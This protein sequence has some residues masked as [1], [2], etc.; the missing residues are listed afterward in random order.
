MLFIGIYPQGLRAE[1]ALITA[2]FFLVAS[3]HIVCNL[4]R[5]DVGA[6]AAALSI[7]EETMGNESALQRDTLLTKLGLSDH[8]GTGVVNVPVHRASTILFQSSEELA[9]A[10]AHRFDKGTLFY[11]RFGTPDTF[12]FEDAI[13]AL[14]GGY[15]SIAVPSGLAACVLPLVGMLKSGDHVLVTD[16]VYEPLRAT[17][18]ECLSER[19]V[20]VTFYDPSLGAD[21]AALFTARTRIVYA[22]APGSLTFEMQ[23]LRVLSNVTHARGALLVCDNTWATPLYCNPI[24]LGAD[25]VVHAGTKYI[26]G[27]SDAMLGIVVVKDQKHYRAL[28]QASNWLGYH[29]S[30]D[31]IFLASRGLRTLAVRMERHQQN[32]LALAHFLSQQPA[33]RRVIHPALP[34][35]PGHAIFKRDFSGASGLFAAVLSTSLEKATAF[36]D[37]LSLFGI[38]FSWG[39]YESLAL[40]CD[41]SHARTATQWQERGI[42]VRFHAGLEHQ[43]D[44]L[45]DLATALRVT[46]I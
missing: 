3:F 1:K 31:D 21:L 5:Q 7:M 30:P 15:G 36:V 6:R 24:S 14:E 2:I 41:P 18:T 33:V 45:D 27:H 37:S 29:V 10:K 13:A 16:S 4:S 17:L 22:E 26:V 34:D 38:G 11:G 23:D 35:C 19:G 20:D 25:I 46:G 43:D 8:D 42:L 12:A 9:K 28:R 40:V 32:G 39:G 44:L